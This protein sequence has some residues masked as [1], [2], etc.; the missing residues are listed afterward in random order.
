MAL[1][2]GLDQFL[3]TT[4]IYN[5]GYHQRWR[6]PPYTYTVYI[7]TIIHESLFVCVCFCL[8]RDSSESSGPI[9]FIQTCYIGSTWPQ[10]VHRGVFIFAGGLGG[11][12]GGN[13]NSQ[14]EY[15]SRSTTP[16]GREYYKSL[17]FIVEYSCPHIFQCN[18]PSASREG[19]SLLVDCSKCC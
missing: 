1:Y 19:N 4:T 16:G 3:K 7:V 12:G 8:L 6:F 17:P 15:V 11:R 9:H 13:A 2:G 5:I 18:G 10:L 14:C